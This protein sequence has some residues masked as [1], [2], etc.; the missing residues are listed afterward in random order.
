MTDHADVDR[1][2]LEYNVNGVIYRE[3]YCATCGDWMPVFLDGDTPYCNRC[4]GAFQCG[5]CGYEIDLT[6]ACQRPPD[7]EGN[8]CPESVVT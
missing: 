8:T 2:P 5:E 7:E 1:S 6:G 3:F 4:G